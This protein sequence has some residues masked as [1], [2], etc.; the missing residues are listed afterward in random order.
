[1]RILVVKGLPMSVIEIARLR[2]NPG[3]PLEQF[4]EQNRVIEADYLP[5][6]PGFLGRELASGDDD[7]Y[8]VV[9]H[10]RSAAD[11]D[12]SMARFATD[13]TSQDFMALIDPTTMSMARYSVITIE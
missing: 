10:W 9:V 6:Q 4:V 12:A 13:P 2:L 7:E 1:M 5:N 8:I 11:A 3:T